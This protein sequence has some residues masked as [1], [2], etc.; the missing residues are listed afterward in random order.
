MATWLQIL[1]IV[2]N[3]TLVYLSFDTNDSPRS[4]F[5]CKF[6]FTIGS[7]NV[8]KIWVQSPCVLYCMRWPRFRFLDRNLS[9]FFVGFLENLRHPKF[10]S[11]I[12]WPVTNTFYLNDPLISVARPRTIFSTKGNR[13]SKL[14]FRRPKKPFSIGGSQIYRLFLPL[15]KPENSIWKRFTIYYR[16]QF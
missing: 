3:S 14:T 16:S 9:I 12:N 13:K 7:G 1:Q 11:E 15:H 2:G 6:K 10:H 8:G 4:V 5:I